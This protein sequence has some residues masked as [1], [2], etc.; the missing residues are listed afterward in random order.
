MLTNEKAQEDL[1]LWLLGLLPEQESQSLEERL[2]TDSELYDELFIVEEELIDSYIA[3][4]L[5]DDE[6]SAFQSYF[7]NSPERQE[8]FRIANALRVY[9]GDAKETESTTEEKRRWPF[10]AMSLVAAAVV[11]AALVWAW[12]P[13]STGKSHRAELTPG[14]QTREGGTVQRITIPPGTDTL[15]LDLKLTRND[16]QKYRA[17]LL[18]SD[19][20]TIQI[21]E[22][23]TGPTLRFSVNTEQIPPGEYQIKV[24]GLNTSGTFE[25]ADSYRFTIKN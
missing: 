20:G 6:R 18:N 21:H 9:I 22:N 16:F 25:S 3:G 5:S 8:Q 1:R 7:M 10:A 15:D 13:A 4:R 11:I 2:I 17:T 24:D 14:G 12:L 23:L 19:G